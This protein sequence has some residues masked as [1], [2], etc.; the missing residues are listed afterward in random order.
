[1]KTDP[2]AMPE[3]TAQPLTDPTTEPNVSEPKA[4][5]SGEDLVE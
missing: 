5:L 3:Q 4:P 1:M 2:A